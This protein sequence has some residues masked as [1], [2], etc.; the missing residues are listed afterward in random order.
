MSAIGNIGVRYRSKFFHA[1]R[2]SWRQ[3]MSHH[4]GLLRNFGAMQHVKR[5]AIACTRCTRRGQHRKAT[6]IAAHG[7]G[8]TFA[9]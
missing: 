8:V 4:V 9:S 6:L 5:A 2:K 7:F 1:S 3:L